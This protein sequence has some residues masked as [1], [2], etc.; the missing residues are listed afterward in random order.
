MR[1]YVVSGGIRV[2]CKVGGRN[3]LGEWSC[4]GGRV[5]VELIPGVGGM[6]LA[7][8]EGRGLWRMNN[9][10]RRI[11]SQGRDLYSQLIYSKGRERV[12]M[13]KVQVKSL[14]RFDE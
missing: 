3:F 8:R 14:S 5:G 6:V 7:G 2:R 10:E 13:D 9:M 11:L 12:D 4:G 1:F